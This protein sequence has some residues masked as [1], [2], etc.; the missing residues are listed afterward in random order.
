LEQV[1]AVIF[2]IR[3]NLGPK[4]ATLPQMMIPFAGGTMGKRNWG[5]GYGLVFLLMLLPTMAGAQT[6]APEGSLS[7]LFGA[8]SY[9]AAGAKAE[10]IVLK[11]LSANFARNGGNP[12]QAITDFL[13]SPQ[14]S[15]YMT[16]L[17]LSGRDPA[18]LMKKWV[19]IVTPP[20][21]IY[22]TPRPAPSLAR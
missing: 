9:G 10:A 11:E 22:S 13:N 18:E 8:P 15:R 12:Q 4:C 2:H 5:C 20:Q 7:R 1:T 14:S 16:D 6:G 17:A 21:T 19:D 3:P